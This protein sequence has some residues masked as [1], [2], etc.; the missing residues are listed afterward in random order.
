[1]A[2]PDHICELHSRPY[3]ITCKLALRTHST[4]QFDHLTGV[5]R[6]DSSTSNLLFNA[7][8]EPKKAQL[9]L[10]RGR[11][12]VK[13]LDATMSRRDMIKRMMKSEEK[14]NHSKIK[15]PTKREMEQH[16]CENTQHLPLHP[17][18]CNLLLINH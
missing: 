14:G 15:A 9:A 12:R 1:M 5:V 6:H 16:D 11:A 2:K 4:P 17:A 8:T 3:E 13:T 18:P 10:A 7:H